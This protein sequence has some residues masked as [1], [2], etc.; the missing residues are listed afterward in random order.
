MTATQFALSEEERRA[1]SLYVET[2]GQVHTMKALVISRDTMRCLRDPHG[3][4]S[5]QVLDRARA[6]LSSV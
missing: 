5:R 6:A 2:H 3:R 1:F 4:V